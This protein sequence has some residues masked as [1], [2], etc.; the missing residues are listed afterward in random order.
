MI[1]Q[2]ARLRSN[3]V[4]GALGGFV[5]FVVLVAAGLSFGPLAVYDP[6]LNT[7]PRPGVALVGGLLAFLPHLILTGR[8]ALRPLNPPPA[9]SASDAAPSAPSR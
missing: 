8:D 1:Q 4:G 6:A 5:G 9:T 7:H 3:I 2:T